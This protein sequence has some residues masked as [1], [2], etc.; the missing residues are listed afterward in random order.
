MDALISG[1][2]G[3][4]LLLDAGQLTSFDV[5]DP[6]DLVPRTAADFAYLF[7]E[8]QDLRVLEDT[9][10]E[11]VRR[12]LKVDSDSALA[13]DLALISLDAELPDEIR[14]EALQSLGEL[15]ADDQIV[16]RLEN[17]LYARP[18]PEDSDLRG[19][20][21]LCKA[22]RPL[23]TL[24]LL[25]RFEERQP[26]ISEVSEAWDLIPT[27]VFGDYDQK[28]EFLHTAAREG[29]FRSLVLT[30]ETQNTTSTFLLTAGLN[31]SVRQLSN[32][33]QVLQDWTASFRQMVLLVEDEDMVRAVLK[34]LLEGE[35][36]QVLSAS[37]GEEAL[38]ISRDLRRDIKLMIMD[39]SLPNMSGFE[40]VRCVHALRPSLPVLMMS[41]F[42]GESIAHQGLMS[43]KLSVIQKPFD[44]ASVARKVR[45]VLDS[46]H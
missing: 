23:L 20:L 22:S 30:R 19:A 18:L 35:G 28:E 16:E 3:R 12:E 26:F 8:M 14:K 11:S 33:R 34:H 25:R 40:L 9:D 13:L 46:Q 38:S 43:E 17:I 2:N 36:Y 31:N 44:S 42:T 32:H 21:Q 15:L 45:E 4:A 1:T 10:I 39:A 6:S 37:T 5:D 41:G 7:G 24:R 27:K 29:L